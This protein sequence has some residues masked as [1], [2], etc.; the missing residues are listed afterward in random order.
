MPISGNLICSHPLPSDTSSP[1]WRQPIAC[2]RALGRAHAFSSGERWG[3]A[4]PTGH[5]EGW[6]AG[7]WGL[8]LKLLAWCPAGWH[9]W[10]L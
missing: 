8:H 7:T 1:S 4:E 10:T 9:R 2:L 6:E 3:P 5:S